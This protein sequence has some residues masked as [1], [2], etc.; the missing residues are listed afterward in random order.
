EAQARVAHVVRVGGNDQIA[1]VLKH[2]DL[3]DVLGDRRGR[4]ERRRVGAR[5][6]FDR[7][8]DRARAARLLRLRV[9]RDGFGQ[10]AARAAVGDGLLVGGRRFTRE[11]AL[12]DRGDV[13]RVFGQGGRAGVDWG[14]AAATAV[15][16]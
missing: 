1:V 13:R 9:Q 11:Q 4:G 3:A 2:G 8:P 6:L 16:A 14:G 12:A 5:R 10:T 15:A 7:P